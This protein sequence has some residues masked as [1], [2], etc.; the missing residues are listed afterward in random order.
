M[1]RVVPWCE[2]CRKS[3]REETSSAASAAN[4][5]DVKKILIHAA[6]SVLWKAK[7]P[8]WSHPFHHA[9]GRG[10]AQ[11]GAS[12]CRPFSQGPLETLAGAPINAADFVVMGT[13]HSGFVL[14]GV[15]DPSARHVWMSQLCLRQNNDGRNGGVNLNHTQQ[16]VIAKSA[17]TGC[18]FQVAEE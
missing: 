8:S 3:G 12:P 9:Q 4:M 10:D 18:C 2:G 5:P 7:I 16:E 15:L 11:F 6:F 14:V 17:T 13:T 1:W